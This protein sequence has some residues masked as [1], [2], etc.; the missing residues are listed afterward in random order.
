MYY[1]KQTKNTLLLLLFLTTMLFAKDKLLVLQHS[2]IHYES[3]FNTLKMEVESDFELTKVISDEKMSPKEIKK[4]IAKEKPKLIILMNNNNIKAYAAYVQTLPKDSEVI[5]SISLMAAFVEK[6]I[7]DLPNSAGITYEIPIVTS[8]VNL[9]SMMSIPK[10]KLGIIYRD[11]LRDFIEKNKE[12]CKAEGIDVKTFYV[13][14]GETRYKELLKV[15]LKELVEKH[16]ANTIWVPNDPVFLSKDIIASVWKPFT[17]KYD[18]PVIVGV[19]SFLLSDVNFGSFAVLPDHSAL[20]QQAAN[21]VFSIQDNEWKT[22]NTLIEAPISIFKVL[23][24]KQAKK[25]ID[26]TEVPNVDKIIQ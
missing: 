3:V 5:P 8:V 26:T 23:N 6:E 10:V 21:I 2:G 13:P 9:R 16:E 4:L 19:E 25:H 18:V 17:D 11:F 20:G 22:D 15:G 14:G 1:S 12:Y 7:K 24:F